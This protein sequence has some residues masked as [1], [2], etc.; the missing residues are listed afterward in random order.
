MTTGTARHRTASPHCPTLPAGQIENE[1]NSWFVKHPTRK[2]T[3][4][5]N[6]FFKTIHCTCPAHHS[7]SSSGSATCSDA[8][9][10][11]SNKELRLLPC[12]PATHGEHPE[13]RRPFGANPLSSPKSRIK[14]S[15]NLIHTSFSPSTAVCAVRLHAA[16]D[17]SSGQPGAQQSPRQPPPGQ[18]SD[19][20]N[21]SRC[22]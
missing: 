2:P 15:R 16:H 10:R 4:H 11:S 18:F 21:R 14:G 19:L 7:A 20:L 13:S 8:C 9:H 6:S 5:S 3:C 22:R 1:G 12:K 17:S